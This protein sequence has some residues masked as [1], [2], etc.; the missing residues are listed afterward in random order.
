[1]TISEFLNTIQILPEY[2]NNSLFLKSSDNYGCIYKYLIKRMSNDTAMRIEIFIELDEAE[3][4]LE[5]ENKTVKRY[6]EIF[7]AR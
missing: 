1:M 3:H 5:L 4:E 2:V 6:I 7:P